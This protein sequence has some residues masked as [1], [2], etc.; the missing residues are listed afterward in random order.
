MA[1]A[2]ATPEQVAEWL[3]VTTDRLKAW[4]KKPGKGPAF[5]KV[6]GS[7]RY[8]WSDVHSWCSANRANSTGGGNGK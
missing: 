8:A 3:Q 5:V 2:L 1:N 6:G 4:R 7:I